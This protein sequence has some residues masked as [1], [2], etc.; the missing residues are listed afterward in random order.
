MPP[1]N[2]PGS[3]LCGCGA[4]PSTC[5]PPTFAAEIELAHGGWPAPDLANPSS[6][7]SITATDLPTTIVNRQP[8]HRRHA[9]SALRLSSGS[10][11]ATQPSSAPTLLP[12]NRS[13]ASAASAPRPSSDGCS[14]V[15]ADRR[16]EARRAPGGRPPLVATGEKSSGAHC[17]RVRRDVRYDHLHGKAPA[18]EWGKQCVFDAYFRLPH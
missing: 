11:P 15:S 17:V 13:T 14:P 6:A 12:A 1:R 2:R 4:P 3:E 7:A 18:G 8:R 9:C 16:T 10:M 5:S